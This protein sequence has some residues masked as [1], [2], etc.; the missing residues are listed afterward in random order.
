MKKILILSLL[1]TP[2]FALD[3]NS[4]CSLNSA[5]KTT[6][7]VLMSMS[8]VN[9][10]TRSIVQ[11]EIEHALKKETG[12]KFKVKINSFWGTNIAQGEFGNST[13]L[14]KNFS[15]DKISAQKLYLETICPY[16]KISYK[17]DKL[18]FDSNIVLKFSAEMNEK[19]LSEMLKQQVQILDDK[20]VFKVKVSALG[21][22]TTFNVSA[23][24][25]V[26]DNK[27]QLCNIKLN[28]TSLKA[29]KY[30]YIFNNLT[31]FK[32]D[33]DKNTKAYI[34][35]DNVK[36]NNSIVNIT[37]YTLIPHS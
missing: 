26:V 34:K 15:H 14:S 1:L 35:I 21:I 27:I 19:N 29:S 24:L 13:A 20:I 4:Y 28:G 25:E 17:N 8:G 37:G 10:L 31:N 11:K 2:C 36:I 16:N 6:S 3:Y 18:N 22:K 30:M 7:G 23:G 33:L 5:S 9:F 12:S 32:V